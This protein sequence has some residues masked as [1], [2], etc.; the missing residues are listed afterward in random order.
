LSSGSFFMRPEASRQ[1]CPF[2]D[3]SGIAP[4]DFPCRARKQRGSRNADA[5]TCDVTEI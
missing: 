1:L 2:P 3:A 4:F 5:E